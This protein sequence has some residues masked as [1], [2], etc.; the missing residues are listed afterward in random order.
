[1][2]HLV[3]RSLLAAGLFGFSLPA[4]ADLTPEQKLI[5]FQQ[6]AATYA[7]NYAPYEWKVEVEKFD[8]F[9]LRPWLEKVK[10]SKD[11]IEFFEI[12]FQYIGSLNDGHSQLQ[13]PS[14]FQAYLGFVV[15]LYDDKPL[16]DL[17]DRRRLPPARYPFAEGDELISVDGLTV[18][19]WIAKLLPYN[20][21][22]N[23]RSNRRFALQTITFRPQVF[24]PAAHRIGDTATVVIRSGG[25]DESYSIPWSKTGTPMENAGRIP[26]F[27]T[28]APRRPAVAA[29]DDVMPGSKLLASLQNWRMSRP[30][31]SVLN[32]G[33]LSPI[34]RL[35]ANFQVRLG[36]AL[37]DQ[38]L[39]GTFTSGTT[40]IGFIR[41]PDFDPASTTL[42]LQQFAA[43]IA[44][45][46]ANTDGLVID[47]MRN[48]GGN[49][50]YMNELIRLL[51][52]YRFRSIGLEIRATANWIAAFSSEIENAKALGAPAATIALLQTY[53]DSIKTAYAE[54][55]GRTGP[56]P[57]CTVSLDLPP[58]TDART[59][60]IAAYTKPIV[61]LVDEMS[62][63]AGDAFPATLQDSARATILGYRTMGLGGSVIQFDT[64]SFSEIIGGVTVTLMNRKDPIVTSEYP[65]APYVENIGVRPDAYY[66]YMT[67]ANLTDRGAAFVTHFTQVLVQSIQGR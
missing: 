31:N 17:I 67:K 12:C 21:T 8:L 19:E 7:K 10:N 15:D 9:D 57:I 55:R 37:T 47:D 65:T 64:T 41:I 56:L 63:S 24:Y 2:L 5:D 46:E 18:D 62:A 39:S 11:D 20:S 49:A 22:G 53:L 45:F 35:P 43:E 32:F 14:D 1:M 34:Y 27:R 28:A 23:P 48:P 38:F 51:T 6:L 61:V 60:R 44:F 3:R 26:N 13:L 40:R 50:C 54:N 58:A 52:P 36:R 25:K 33:S 30:V 4:V 59:G 42:A 16:I 29:S 66:D